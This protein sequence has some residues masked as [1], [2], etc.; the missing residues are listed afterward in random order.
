MQRTHF[1][2]TLPLY[3]RAVRID[4]NIDAKVGIGIDRY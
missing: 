1:A 2:D 4:P 3:T